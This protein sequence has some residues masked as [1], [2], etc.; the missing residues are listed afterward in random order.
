MRPGV[1][2]QEVEL[3]VGPSSPDV[4]VVAAAQRSNIDIEGRGVRLCFVAGIRKFK[5]RNS[6]LST[7]AVIVE[8]SLA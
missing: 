6:E 2:R 3:I 1:P 8:R 5:S 7:L 4:N